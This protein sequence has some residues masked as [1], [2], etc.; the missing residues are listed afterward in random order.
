MVYASPVAALASLAS[1]AFVPLALAAALGACA[2]RPS[3]S[4]GTDCELATECAVPLVCRLGR[5]REECRSDRDCRVGLVCLRD[6]GLGAC[7]LEGESCVLT[8]DCRAPLVC[9]MGRCTNACE[10]DVDCPPGA[11]CELGPDGSRGCRDS[12]MTRCEHNTD[13]PSPEICAPD[14]VCRE[15]CRADRDC[16]DGTVCDEAGAI[17]VCVRPGELDAGVPDASG[18]DAAG[19]D[20][21]PLDASGL[22]GGVADAGVITGPAPAPVLA[23]GYQHTCAARAG[24]LRCWGSNFTG[25]LGDGLFADRRTPAPVLAVGA[26]VS[27]L[28]S[29]A[30]HACAVGAGGLYCW[31]DNAA[32]QVGDG[33]AAATRATPVLLAGALPTSLACGRDH[34]CAIR[35]GS[36]VCW[37]DNAAGQLGDATTTPRRSP[38][39]AAAL[40]GSPVE[41]SARARETCVVLADGRA[42]CWGENLYGQLGNG[43]ST[44]GA[45][46]SPALVVSLTD[47]VEIVVGATHACARRR[48]GEVLCWGSNALGALGDGSPTSFARETP[49]V[50]PGLPPAVEL[51]A[52][53]DHVC[54]RTLD[55]RV[56][57]W[58]GNTFGQVGVNNLVPTPRELVPRE[59]LGLEPVTELAAGDFH[60]CARGASGLWCWG[61]NSRGQLGDGGTTESFAPRAVSWP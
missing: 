16:R 8:S 40:A 10:E 13:C 5:C 22:D 39:P 41:V 42:Q 34:C 57:C 32:G 6:D 38:T 12:A 50:V 19:A 33:T 24:E 28:A 31:G 43:T 56:Y 21:P 25:Q 20:A 15:Q 58:G 35:G 60:T 55:G 14:G 36:V 29:G 17:N 52:G 53:V 18:L 54:A 3:L 2:A 37:G 4:L 45:T 61:W 44:T 9:L 26:G 23:G 7:E 47:A 48:S 30:G 51:A 46:S 49:G 27:L 1:R 11:A 59:V